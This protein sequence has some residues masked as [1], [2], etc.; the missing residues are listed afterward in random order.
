MQILL[1]RNNKIISKLI[2]RCTRGRY[3]HAAVLLRDG[4]VV[5]ARPFS[6][7]KIYPTIIRA[8][9]NGDTVDYYDVEL[10]EAQE[11]IIEDFLIK[12]EGKKYDYWDILGFVLFTKHETRKGR[13]KWFCGEIIF[14]AF[15]KG[16]IRLLN[17]I[18]AFMVSPEILGYSPL[19][20]FRKS[21]IQVREA[22]RV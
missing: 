18:Q 19:L 16:G 1:Q 21:R 20:K 15:F 11:K 4:R 14:A 17:N 13:G 5:E 22:M 9:S 10:T 3:S 2:R 8:S 12:Q 6:R 7:V